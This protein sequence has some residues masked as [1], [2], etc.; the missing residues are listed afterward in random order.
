MVVNEKKYEKKKSYCYGNSYKG[1][2]LSKTTFW[3]ILAVEKNL[4]TIKKLRG[5]HVNK[6]FKWLLINSQCSEKN[7]FFKNAFSEST[8]KFTLCRIK[9]I[10]C[11]CRVLYVSN[12]LKAAKKYHV[13]IRAQMLSSAVAI[14]TERKMKI[15]NEEYEGLTLSISISVTK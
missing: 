4:L 2:A 8:G 9:T 14:K 12:G 5:Y 6:S 3:P 1:Y 10:C 13:I 15:K 7:A 11:L